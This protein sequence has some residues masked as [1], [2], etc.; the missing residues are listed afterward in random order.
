MKTEDE[1]REVRDIFTRLKELTQGHS[2]AETC[3]AWIKI[4]TW[5]LMG[6]EYD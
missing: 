5:V 4:L 1:V 3:D 2:Y 6:V